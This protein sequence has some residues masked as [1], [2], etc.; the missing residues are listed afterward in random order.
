[1]GSK[2][3]LIIA[4]YWGNDTHVGCKRIKRFIRWFRSGNIEVIVIKA[5]IKE[6]E[7]KKEWGYE[8]TIKD[9][10]LKLGF[11]YAGE[12]Y[13]SNSFSVLKSLLRKILIVILIPDA[14]S[15]WANRILSNFLVKKHYPNISHILSSNPPESAHIASY[16]IARK[17]NKKLIIDMRDGWL[18]EPLSKA[19]N[20]VPFRKTRERKLESKILK[21]ADFIFVTSNDWKRLLNSRLIF[22]KDKT[23][24]LTNGY[25]LKFDIIK[26]NKEK[27]DKILLF[28]TGK[29]TGSSS[30][31]KINILLDILLGSL[32]NYQITGTIVLLGDLEPEEL[33][34]I[35]G[36]RK[37]FF[38]FG[39]DIE[40]SKSISQKEMY[41]KLLSSDGLLL[42]STSQAAVPSKF[43]EYILTKKPIFALTPKNSAVWEI[44]NK[45]PQVFLM[46]YRDKNANDSSVTGFF[47]ACKTGNV[48]SV[49]P[50][51]FTD[52]Y[53]SQIFFDSLGYEQK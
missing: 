1:M 41:E 24:V 46:D 9:P 5:G 35:T 47:D 3:I 48:D 37:K 13:Y 42:L 23:F 28:H 34:L 40:F 17:L 52:E 21:R 39:W 43:F 45:L 36:Y 4:P 51:E 53:L 26:V 2:K 6:S 44:G 33:N 7:E 38:N 31:R 10:A 19:I 30:S 25:P 14:Q 12:Q 18:D 8:I 15:I 20:K 11:N 49:I 16:K 29:F 32:L 50:E 27:R 22:T